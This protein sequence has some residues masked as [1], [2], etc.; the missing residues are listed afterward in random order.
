[1]P[2]F[3]TIQASISSGELS[4]R[5]RG[6][7]DLEIYYAGAARLD[8]FIVRPHGGVFRRGGFKY[9][10]EVKDSSKVTI[11]QELS[12]K[13]DFSYILEFGDDYIRFFRAQL[14]I[15]GAYAA[16][17]T[18][19]YYAPGALVTDIYPGERYRCLLAHYSGVFATDLAASKWVVSGGATDLA[20]EVVTTYDETEVNA[21]RFAQDE[22]DLFIVHKNHIPKMLIRDSHTAWRLLPMN[23]DGI[24]TVDNITHG[25]D[26]TENIYTGIALGGG[27]GAG[28]EAT[29][30][31]DAA[32]DVT[33]VTITNPG[34]GYL[35]AD[36]G[37]TI[38]NATIGGAADAT[39][40]VLTLIMQ[41]TPAEWGAGN[42]PTL[43]WFYEQ[44]LFFAATPNEPNRIWGSKSADIHDFDLGTG[45]DGEGLDIL[46]NDA[47]KFLWVSTGAAILL[48]AKNGEFL[49]SASSAD[50]ALTPTSIKIT[51][52]TGYGGA[53]LRP[54]QIDAHTVFVQRG[55][56]KFRRMEYDPSSYQKD[57][58][59]AKDITFFSE[60]IAE[61]GVEDIT[62]A[63]EPD[64]IIWAA[65]NDGVLIG[66]TYEPDYEIFAWHKHPVG[67]TDTLV[68]SIAVIDG[69]SV[70]ED[71]LWA[72]ISRTIDESTVQ[73]I[74]FL[75]QGLTSE[76]EQEDAFFVDSG[77]TKTGAAFTA[78]DGLDHLEGEEVLVLGDGAV[79]APKTVSAGAITLD[80]AVVKAHAGLSYN[81]I[82][83]TFPIEG[84]NPIGTSQGKIKRIVTVAL[85]LDRSL[86]FQYG[87]VGGTLDTYYFG[88]PDT[89]DDPIP[90]FTGD[91]EPKPFPDGYGRQG[92]IKIQQSDPLPLSILAILFEATTK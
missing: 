19:T 10:T 8:N 85:R 76:D 24:L 20:Q 3:D 81:S 82:L 57:R 62:Y 38:D 23:E 18:T 35:E 92:T 17:T 27:T 49:L 30:V 47:T 26:H 41:N 7:V 11:V 69:A 2:R 48:G 12:Y 70:A 40:D 59:T 75:T 43:I 9:V 60:H 66:L 13:D 37:L 39:V 21:L 44:R 14:Q 77:V 72:V 80:T 56:R 50:S 45:L 29:V 64:S 53:F 63:N 33:S 6:R 32:G 88:P 1:M 42:Y 91:T 87:A 86:G 90:L 25:G 65:R 31:V 58:Y 46:S 71:E 22:K 78:F 74:E 55:K 89:M 4:P 52:S 51:K 54:I 5:L 67:G 83:E 36:A 28:A 61:S 68:K 34:T 16:W 15:V 84:G 73:Y 79:Q